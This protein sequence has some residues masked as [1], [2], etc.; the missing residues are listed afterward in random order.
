M[1]LPSVVKLSS[2]VSKHFGNTLYVSKYIGDTSM[3]T[4]S[5]SVL[6]SGCVMCKFLVLDEFRMST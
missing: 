1:V 2:G 5:G 3:T 4:D 6:R